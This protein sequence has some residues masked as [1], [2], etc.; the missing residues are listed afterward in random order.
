MQQYGVQYQCEGDNNGTVYETTSVDFDTNFTSSSLHDVP[1]S[2]NGVQ[3]ICSVGGTKKVQILQKSQ[4]FV[5][6][7]SSG[8]GEEKNKSLLANGPL[9]IE[10]RH[11]S[12][13]KHLLFG[14]WNAMGITIRNSTTLSL[15]CSFLF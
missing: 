12:K 2:S 13:N 14:Q 5:T 10:G 1:G 15:W 8:K 11:F 9:T 7:S 4:M 6:N 3:A